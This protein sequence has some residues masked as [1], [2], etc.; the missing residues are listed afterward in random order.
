MRNSLRRVY[1]DR[2]S[3][4]VLLETDPGE[5]REDLVAKSLKFAGNDVKRPN[6]FVSQ[7]NFTVFVGN[8]IR[9][10]PEN[11]YEP[12]EVKKK[13]GERKFATYQ[14]PLHDNFRDCEP[15]SSRS[16]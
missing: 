2:Y 16:L 8:L 7:R 3:H 6:K 4:I 14:V 11:E 12:R 1:D 15:K 5:I 10:D 13:E 9:F